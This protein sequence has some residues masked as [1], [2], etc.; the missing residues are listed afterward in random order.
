[1]K[2]TASSFIA[3]RFLMTSLLISACT[4]ASAFAEEPSPG[5]IQSAAAHHIRPVT[6]P[7]LGVMPFDGGA[8]VNRPE[9]GFFNDAG[10]D[11]PV[12]IA[13]LPAGPDAE[14]TLLLRPRPTAD[15]IP[16][17]YADLFRFLDQIP[18]ISSE[19]PAADDSLYDIPVVRTA[20]VESHMRFFHTA[21]RDRFEQW[22]N[23][24]SHYKPL[25]DKI[26]LEFDLPSDLVF[27]SL[28]ESGFNPKA[29]SRAR[30]AGPWQF[31]KG[32]ARLYGLRVDQYVDER[33]DPI[34]STVAAAR[35]LRDLYDL[36]G[37]WPLAMAAYNAGEGKVMRAL[38][39]AQAESLWDIIR[40]K[41]H[42]KRETREYVPRIMAATIIAKN[43]DR[44]GFS[45]EPTDPHEF[46]EVVVRRSVHLRTV[47]A[48]T[49]ISFVDLKQL[50]PELR[51]DIT[52]PDD[53]EYLLKVPVGSRHA[54]EEKLET[55]KARK[56][57][58]LVVKKTSE[59]TEATEW[60]R[61][62]VGDSLWKIA[63]RFGVSVQELQDWNNLSGRR[64]KPGDLLAL[65][66]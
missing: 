7:A 34:K 55:L 36:F 29:Y 26:F 17:R 58:V 66:P 14:P 18:G 27:L 49:G 5:M 59:Q 23:R 20:N 33:R 10:S 60:Y 19:E 39:K 37:T 46:E 24:L 3:A 4:A 64:I 57:P 15:G 56:A 51:R 1:V 43:P 61:V 31:M 30:A 28:V 12:D 11:E 44:Y 54:V 42:L 62:R 50:N 8:F 6:Q 32:T 21:I 65:V 13:F 63:K 48:A 52:P 22:L 35:Y 2:H 40:T 47:A 53:P 41:K 38:Q 9:R 16:W 45:H 25:V